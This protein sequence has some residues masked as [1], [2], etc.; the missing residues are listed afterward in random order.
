MAN[1]LINGRYV[2]DTAE[3][4]VSTGAFLRLK[5]I[6]FEGG[7][8]VGKCILHDGGGKVIW[9][10]TLGDVSVSGDNAGHTFG[11]EGTIVDG[12]DLDTLSAGVCIVYL[13]KL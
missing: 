10:A 9:Q 3:P 6:Y 2:L 7:G 13:G 1:A 12:M 8:D 4:V 11:G 5:S